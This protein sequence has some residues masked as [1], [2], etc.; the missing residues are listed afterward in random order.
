MEPD[1]NQVMLLAIQKV[2]GLLRPAVSHQE[3]VPLLDSALGRLCFH[4]SQAFKVLFYQD[5]D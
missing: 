4:G 5:Q 1:F 2:A 3:R